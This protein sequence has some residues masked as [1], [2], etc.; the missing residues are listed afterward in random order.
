MTLREA[1][2]LYHRPAQGHRPR[3]VEEY[4]TAL[5]HWERLSGDPDV[6]EVDNLAMLEF[7]RAFEQSVLRRTGAPPGPATVRK[8]LVQLQAIFAALGPAQYGNPFGL[9]L[10][11]QIPVCRKPEAAAAAVIT[12]SA[13]EALAIYQHCATARWPDWGGDPGDWWRCLVV[14]LWCIGS[15]R[16]EFLSLRWDDVDLPAQRLTIDPL[17]RGRHPVKPIPQQLYEQMRPLLAPP[18]EFWFQCP[19]SKQLYRTWQAIQAAAGVAVRRAAGD[20]RAPFYCFHEF[21]KTCGTLWFAVSPGAA[22]QVLG[23]ASLATTERYYADKARLA[24]E[25]AEQLPQLTAGGPPPPPPPS[26]LRLFAG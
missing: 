14:Y 19:R 4:H 18:R 10:I 25:A 15:R 23:H 11:A 13:E 3:T 22:Q 26:P 7:R 9:G 6:G 5:K 12:A 21:R 1:Y 17:K 20:R 24:R 8:T 2:E 16:N